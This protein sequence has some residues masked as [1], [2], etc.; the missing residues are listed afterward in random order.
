MRRPMAMPDSPQKL[1]PIG[2]WKAEP[3]VSARKHQ[4]RHPD[5]KGPIALPAELVMWAVTGSA[6]TL[7]SLQRL[8]V[9]PRRRFG[10]F[11]RCRSGS[12][13]DD[14]SASAGAQD[15]WIE[16]QRPMLPNAHESRPRCAPASDEVRP[17]GR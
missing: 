4:D 3:M 6:V 7:G 12:E 16:G 1:E 8:Q 15:L 14:G 17:G 13:F 9:I 11:L 10:L 5:P 2:S